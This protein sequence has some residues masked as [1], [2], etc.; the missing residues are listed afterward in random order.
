[1][2]RIREGEPRTEQAPYGEPARAAGAA[3]PET[4]ILQPVVAPV[5]LGLFAWSVAQ[6][7][8][9]AGLIGVYTAADEVLLAP[10]ALLLAGVAQFAAAMWAFRA[11]DSLSTAMLGVWGSFW[12]GYGILLLLFGGG[13]LARPAGVF[14]PLALIFAPLAGVTYVGA[15]AATQVNWS[16]FATLFLLATGSA[17]ASAGFF[18]GSQAILAAAGVIFIL[19][20]A[21]GWWTAS[22]LLL[23]AVFHRSVW[24]LGLR[25]PVPQYREA[26][27]EPGIYS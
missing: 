7:A 2:E 3:V 25:R 26:M 19:S 11:R 14:I 21:A 16:L 9:A 1:M 5:I 6:S 24:P 20:A 27:G 23:R 12:I 18:T 15:V 8:V 22:G 17:V 10:F 13:I 4:I